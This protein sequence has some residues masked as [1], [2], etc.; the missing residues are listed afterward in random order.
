[1]LAG[2]L[3][4]A[5]PLASGPVLRWAWEKT[6]TLGLLGGSLLGVLL[7]FSLPN[8]LLG[9]VCPFAMKL[10]IQDLGRTGKAAGNIYAISAVGSVIGTFTPVLLLTYTSFG[11]RHSIMLFGALL[12]AAALLLLSRARDLP[13]FAACALF[14]VHLPPLLPVK[15]VIAERESAYN[16]LQVVQQQ[17]APGVNARF[18]VADWGV[19]SM[20]IPGVFRTG[21]YY[22]YLLLAPLLREQPK[23]WL[24]R[25]L[26]VGSAAGTAAKQI[27]QAYG[28][29]DIEGVE[30]DPAIVDLGRKYFAM[31]EANFHVHTTDGRTY[32]AASKEPYDWVIVDAYQGSEIPS[33]LITKE[34]FQQLKEHMTPDGVLSINVAWYEPDD[35]E[36]VR[37][38]AATLAVVFPH[39]YAVTGI[40]RLS[41]AVMLAGS[42]E[43]TP[44]RLRR[45]RRKWG[46]GI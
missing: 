42:E 11:V 17:V 38:L 27:T 6:P 14:A 36:L 10:S 32:L 16:Y 9:C 25:V 20:Y 22:D 19:H 44:A 8:L 45:G 26:I 15:A 30:I 7:L 3:I 41:G 33:H 40:S 46:S 39:Y 2:L 35:Q 23:S 29:V 4:M 18:M 28:P 31:N 1:M 24:K 13:A 12:I 43:L 5:L 21:E 37:R 34:F